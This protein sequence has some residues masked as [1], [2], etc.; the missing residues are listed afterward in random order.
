LKVIAILPTTLRGVSGI[1]YIMSSTADI[2][3]LTDKAGE[4]THKADRPTLEI[5]DE[6]EVTPEMIEAGMTAYR[7]YDH[8][9]E[10]P[11]SLV[12]AIYEA[13]ERLRPRR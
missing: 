6:I 13:M 9:V 8:R 3:Y 1:F 7:A 11:V 10:E 2:I 12:W 4:H 5:S